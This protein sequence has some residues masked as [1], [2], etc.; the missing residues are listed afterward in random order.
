MTEVSVAAEQAAAGKRRRSLW[1]PA[2]AVGP[3]MVFLL[4]SIGPT[5]LVSNSA[6]GANYGYSLLWTLVVIGLSHFVLL[7]A[8]ARFVI[9]TGESLLSGY[10]R[11]ARWSPWVFLAAIVLRRHLSNL[12]H[13]LLLGTAMGWLF[14]SQS[15]WSRNAFALGSGAAAFATMYS[16]GYRTVEK[17]CKPLA[18]LLGAT[19]L[20]TVLW[21]RPDLGMAWE[22]IA[23]PSLPPD[24]GGQGMG[25]AVVLLMLA[26]SGVGSLNNLKY[27]VFI[28]EKGWRSPS[29][30]RIQRI[31]LVISV[32]GAF[33]ISAMLQVAA[34]AVLRPS[35]LTVGR[36]EDL[37]P[38]FTAVLGRPGR[39]LMALGLWTTVFATYIGSNTGYAL[40]VCDILASASGAGR[41]P[42]QRARLYRWLLVFFCVSPLYVLWTGWRPVPLV[43]ASSLLLTLA[44]PLVTIILLR[45]VTDRRKMGPLVNSKLTTAIMLTLVVA[46]L[47]VSYHAVMELLGRS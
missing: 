12:F 41:T 9:A 19:V 4:S 45:L 37:V 1:R 18:V 36:A 35:G 43:I 23:H 46:S 33:L 42:E 8:T 6:A 2:L 14:G 11:A 39:I 30:L 3:G 13:I 21:S 7:E 26:G 10:A 29:H 20:L 40:M 47:A 22:G 27:S 24:A 32:L 31:D 44:I 25:V 5:D 17:Y 38:L 15:Q 16:G 28:Y 34:A